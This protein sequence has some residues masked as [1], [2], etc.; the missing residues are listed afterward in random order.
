MKKREM[1]TLRTAQVLTL[2]LSTVFLIATV[3]A[4]VQVSIGNVHPGAIGEV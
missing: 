3:Y 1:V 2:L 4:I